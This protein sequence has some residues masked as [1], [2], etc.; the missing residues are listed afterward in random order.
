MSALVFAMDAMLYA[1]TGMLDRHDDDIMV[2]TAICKV[3]C[4]EMGWRVVN[5]AMQIMGG[6]GYMT[7]NQLERTF[8]DSRIN[9]I[10]EGANEAMQSFIFAYGGKQLAERMLGVRQ[11]VGWDRHDSIA[12]NLSRVW[13][14][15]QVPGV[16]GAAAAL[17]AELFIGLRRPAPKLEGLH[18]SLNDA[19]RGLASAVR[20][21]SH[22]F[23]RA[24]KEYAETII[25]RQVVQAR[26]ADSAMWLHAWACVL[27]KLDRDLRGGSPNPAQLEHDR[28][29]GH[30]FM[31]MAKREIRRSLDAVF[32][33]DDTAMQ[34]AAEAALNHFAGMP[35][36]DYVIHEASPNAKGTGRRI[37]QDGIPQFP[38]GSSN[39]SAEQDALMPAA[40]L[41]DLHGERV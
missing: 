24:S 33:H 14:G 34:A 21:H 11:A 27:S 15:L 31:A 22:A 35:N 29:A 5:D 26:L 37:E 28:A 8:R 30:C 25:S 18:D 7:E 12:R 4:S 32:H 10:V 2:E 36:D 40:R 20:E 6:E 17:G 9:L 3:F 19:A 13:H 1:A 23:V 41:A 39:G 38:G 16:F